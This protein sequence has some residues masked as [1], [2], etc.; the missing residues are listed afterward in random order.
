MEFYVLL[1]PVATEAAFHGSQMRSHEQKISRL[2]DEIFI[3]FSVFGFK[4]R[5]IR[6]TYEDIV[7]AGFNRACLPAAFVLT[8]LAY[9]HEPI[10]VR[11]LMYRAQAVGLFPSTAAKFYDQTARVVLK[12]RRAG[13]VPY[14]WIVDSTRRRLKPSSWSSLSDFGEDAARC[15]RLDL[16]SRQSD[17]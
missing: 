8:E 11:G 4:P 2:I 3:E 6:Q 5:F 14:S 9:N 12:L 1:R 16:W 10:T 17:Y 7:R 13:I 15:Y